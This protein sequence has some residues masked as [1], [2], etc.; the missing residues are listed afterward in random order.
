MIDQNQ[1]AIP[2]EA[3]AEDLGFHMK[4]MHPLMDRSEPSEMFAWLTDQS[5]RE[6][7]DRGWAAA[8]E[9]AREKDDYYG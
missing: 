5:L 3:H 6:A 8:E 2:T 7:F 9:W 4:E 1:T